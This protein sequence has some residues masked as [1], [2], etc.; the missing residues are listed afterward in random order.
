MRTKPNI[1][2]IYPIKKA[3][4]MPDDEFA[5]WWALMEGLDTIFKYADKYDIDMDNIN[6]NTKRILDEYVTPIS[7]DIL[8]DITNARAAAKDDFT[9][10][11]IEL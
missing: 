3:A 5:R 8:H 7:G 9:K 11:I 1:D 6:L 4:E 10:S 2:N